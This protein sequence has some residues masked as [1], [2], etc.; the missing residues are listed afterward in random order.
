MLLAAVVKLRSARA[1][2]STRLG[3]ASRYRVRN[4]V[5]FIFDALG[6]I[7]FRRAYRMTYESFQLLFQKLEPKLGG[8][9]GECPENHRHVTNGMITKAVRLACTIRYFAGGSPYDIMCKY[10]VSH[11]EVFR[12]VWFVVDAVNKV[13][14][15][16]ISYPSTREEQMRIADGFKKKSGAGFTECAGAIDGILIWIHRPTIKESEL[17]GVGS[18]KYLCAVDGL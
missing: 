15:F 11:T 3:M 8:L 18:T 5:A 14:D 12:S 2:E 1:K 6:P 13:E 17:S 10:G 16:H 7:Y 4:S 9:I